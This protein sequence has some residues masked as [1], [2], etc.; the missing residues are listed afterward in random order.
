MVLKNLTYYKIMNIDKKIKELFEVVEQEKKKVEELNS[1]S[2][3]KWNTNCSFK[4]KNATVNVNIQ[5]ASKD[6]IIDLM[7][8]LLGYE[9]FNKLS[10][11]ILGLESSEKFYGFTYEQWVDDFKKRISIIDLKERREKLKSL[12]SRLN[13]IISPEQRREM[14]LQAIINELE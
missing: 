3:S 11:Q 4:P 10:C 6:T 9:K 7:S 12:E 2:K 13:G 8:N 5:T 1:T 14:E